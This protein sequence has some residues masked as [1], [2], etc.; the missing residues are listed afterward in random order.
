MNELVR[1]RVVVHGRVQGVWFR[2]ATRERCYAL[3]SKLGFRTLVT[4]Y[5]PTADSVVRDYA[6]VGSMA[7]LAALVE[8][9]RRS[10]RVAL[11]LI[12]DGTAPVR[13]TLVGVA[14]STAPRQARY[15]P[16]GHQGF[17]GEGS[18]DRQR[19]L[20]LLAPVLEDPAIA[21]VGHDLKADLIVFRDM[22][23]TSRDRIKKLFDEGKTEEEVIALKPLA[24]LDA[25]WANNPQHAV[26]HTRNVYNSFKR[27]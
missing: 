21:K 4:E 20:V 10:P 2:G 12:T 1:R 15:V 23:V 24:D 26:G 19:A 16:V 9:L 3:F 27:F 25:T 22:L 7:E 5:A 11:R 18:L 13:A 17:M 8:E 6:I 14:V